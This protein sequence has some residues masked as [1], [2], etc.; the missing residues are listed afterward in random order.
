VGRR[1]T[2]SAGGD[3]RSASSRDE[4]QRDV[5]MLAGGTGLAPLK[6]LVEQL[7]A[8]GGRRRV[9]LYL[10]ARTE[11][12]LYDLKAMSQLASECPWLRVVPA[13]SDDPYA[14]DVTQGSVVDV[15]LHHDSWLNHE[16]FVCGSEA[17]VMGSV[18]TLVQRG[19]SPDQI[20][21][22]SF[23]RPVA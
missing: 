12:D 10:G 19:I 8:E 23:Q 18:N 3:G 2:L 4:G 7:A 9:H 15:A 5:L 20:R 1:L 11:R 16:I 21:Y 13:V 14:S 6:A 22:E 17:M